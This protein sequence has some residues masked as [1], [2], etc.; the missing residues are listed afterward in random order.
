MEMN[1]RKEENFCFSAQVEFGDQL[2]T[3]AGLELYIT[4]TEVVQQRRCV[5]TN[6][7]NRFSEKRMA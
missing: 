1:C 4:Q 7:V 5:M 3:M 6:L 2:V